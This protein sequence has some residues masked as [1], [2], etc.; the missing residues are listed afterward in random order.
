[1]I[2]PIKQ[3]TRGFLLP[4]AIVTAFVAVALF[5]I[6]T[7]LNTVAIRHTEE[8]VSTSH[9][10]RE[11]T[12]ETISG[13]TDAET[14]QRGFLLTG[15][16][17]FLEPHYSGIAKANDRLK[18]LAQLAA[19]DPET[20]SCVA[21]LDE[22]FRKQHEHLKETIAMRHREPLTRIDDEALDLVKSGRGK[23][24][25]EAARKAANSIMAIQEA[26]L[27]ESETSM[28]NRTAISRTTI[29]IGN[30][31]A[32]TLI[33]FV[34]LA[35]VIDRR[36]RDH[37]ERELV[38]HQNEL[39]AVLDSAF[40]GI[41]TYRDDL[42]IRYMNPAAAK[43]LGVDLAVDPDRDWNMRNFLPTGFQIGQSFHQ[44][45]GSLSPKTLPLQRH[46]GEAL[47]YEGSAVRT[48]LADD[49]FIAIK[50]RDTSETE[51]LRARQREYASILDKVQ[52][53]I[54]L[55]GLDDC[56]QSWN[57]GAEKLFAISKERA[58][59]QNVVEL[60]F[61]DRQQDWSHGRDLLLEIGSLTSMFTQIGSDGQAL[62]IEKRRSLIYDDNGVPVAQLLLMIDVTARVRD[63]ARQR[64]SQRLE[65]IGT[66][67]GGVAH[68]LNNV[69]T[70]I[71][72]SARLLQ[73]GSKTPERLTENIITSADRGAR[74]IQKLLAFAGGE[75]TDRQQV[76]VREILLELEEILSHTLPQS[77]N[78]QVIVPNSISPIDGDSTELSQVIMNLAIN[79]RDA[80]PNGGS[81]IIKAHDTLVDSARAAR[82]DNLKPGPHISISVSDT[83]TGIPKEII[84][85]IFD[86]FFTTK[87]QGLGTGLGLATTIGIVRS[88]A[89]DIAVTS[90]PGKGTQFVILLPRSTQKA[91]LE[92]AHVDASET[93][94]GHGET[95]LVVDDEAMILEAAAETL[96]G[97]NYKVLT[98][99][100]GPEGVAAYREHVAQI[101][102]VLLDM[103]M[104]GM[105]GQ[106][107]K[108][109]LREINADVKIIASSGL[110]RPSSE[111]NHMN[112]MQGF[113]AKPYT[114]RQLL[115][116]L[117]DVLNG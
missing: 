109:K 60:L 99:S 55:C 32:L 90:E 98:A 69:L 35:A 79:A 103:M 9:A 62:D 18:A 38:R 95:I 96:E 47:Q 37:A 82:S 76:D 87:P 7:F 3:K 108:D 44:L 67:A 104:P 56:I 89:G 54:V 80:M 97:N 100:G 75:K 39:Q 115:R 36:K 58:I 73:R 93:P 78:L 68:D 27:L 106:Q 52:E 112:D 66:L 16:Q 6:I 31:L 33:A 86:P 84:D 42:S 107:V 48:S 94:L 64:R 114:D 117:R 30:C 105:D 22:A 20:R 110:R 74:M 2:N 10:I 14:G 91:R 46:S 19:E 53:A 113:L 85:R 51:I 88:Y 63:E 59:G 72:M 45:D 5:A 4:S 1:M 26:K 65:S 70:P 8:I 111:E 23:A 83:G 49:H 116:L 21:L 92:S 17:S 101:D 13:M 28:Q 77:I 12:Q 15:D 11:A 57:E 71:I 29:T 25:M 43:I 50:F 41:L 102:C 81:L 34:G 40:E 24:A 61:R